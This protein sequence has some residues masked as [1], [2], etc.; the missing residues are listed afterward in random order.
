MLPFE[1]L[2]IFWHKSALGTPLDADG[3][4]NEP[5]QVYEFVYISQ[6]SLKSPPPCHNSCPGF[7]PGFIAIELYEDAST[8]L[9]QG[10]VMHYVGYNFFK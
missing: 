8:G 4:I 10:V 7:L 3:A 9:C 5:P 1:V 2:D 6:I